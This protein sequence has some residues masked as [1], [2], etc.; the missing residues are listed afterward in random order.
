MKLKLSSILLICL[1]LFLIGSLFASNYILKNEYKKISQNKDFE[2]TELSNKP[3]KHLKLVQVDPEVNFNR[4]ENRGLLSFESSDTFSVKTSTSEWFVAGKDTITSKIVDDT[5]IITL[6][7]YVKSLYQSGGVLNLRIKAPKIE[8]ISCVNSS[9]L[10]SN[11]IQD[12]L[13]LSLF[14]NCNFS[15]L[16]GVTNIQSIDANLNDNSVLNLGSSLTINKLN[17]N[18]HNKAKLKMANIKIQDFKLKADEGTSI[19]APS[20][21]FK[22]N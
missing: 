2:Y 13:R 9:F 11:L 19:E 4:T 18:M 17:L 10:S 8:S 6:S 14:G 12:S 1:A 3:F 5:L 15:F 16:K 7:H 21:F 20:K 22:L